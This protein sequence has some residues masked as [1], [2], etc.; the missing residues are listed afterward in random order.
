MI[1]KIDFRETDLHCSM[2]KI[3][4]SYENIK[5]YT[6]NLPIGDII[7][8]DDDGTEKIII[9]RKTLNDL[10]ASIRDGRYSEQSFR[11]NN[12]SLHNHSIVYLL[13]GNIHTYKSSK[14]GR[15]VEKEA[16]LSA[17]T[18]MTYTKGFSI[19]RSADLIESSLW[20]LQTADKISRIKEQNYYSIKPDLDTCVA[21]YSNVVST[22]VKK[23]NITPENIGAIMLSQIPQ[24]SIASANAI[25]KSYTSI[26]S[27][28][29]VLKHDRKALDDVT[30][31]SKNDKSRRISKT[32]IA[33]VIKYLIGEI[34]C[35]ICI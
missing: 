33:N 29:V 30:I 6:E 24:V 32:C 26:D 13:E 22:R 4:T 20:I 18:S 31:A 35:D 2:K 16:L 8:Y 34:K 7:I 27:L 10:A 23:D 19:Y 21:D 1:I 14:Y 11:L 9:E 28:I 3:M 5:I 12:T 15:P 17:M 25:M